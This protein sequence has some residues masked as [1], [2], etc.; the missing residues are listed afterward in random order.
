[1]LEN[2][3][4]AVS[5]TCAGLGLAQHLLL[6][7]ATGLQDDN[8]KVQAAAA[9]LLNLALTLPD[10][11]S[12]LAGVLVSRFHLLI[13]FDSSCSCSPL[14]PLYLLVALIACFGVHCRSNDTGYNQQVKSKSHKQ[15]VTS[16]K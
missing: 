15:Q 1:M 12:D 2:S 9:N 10:A 8:A 13:P 16:K 4:V 7:V 3:V 14:Y 6:I 5:T 11:P